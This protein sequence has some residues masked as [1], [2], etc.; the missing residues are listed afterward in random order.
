MSRRDLSQPSLAD[1]L[2]SH[3]SKGNQFVED[4]SKLVDWSGFAVLFKD[5]H[6]NALGAPGYPPIAMFKI[7]LL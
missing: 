4:V 5:I 7:T 2:V 6:G 3:Y 1:A